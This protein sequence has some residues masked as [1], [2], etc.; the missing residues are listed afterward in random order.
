MNSISGN[1][2]KAI[3]A[4]NDEFESL[5][6]VNLET[7]NYAVFIK[8]KTFGEDINTR[9]LNNGEF[10]F[11]SQLN[12]ENVVYHE[13]R[14]K[15]RNIIT[16]EFI[17]KALSEA[18][19]YDTH[20]RLVVKDRP[21]WVKIRILYKD[22]RKKNIIVGTFN[23]EEEMARRFK[24]EQLRSEL[25]NKM[26]DSDALYIIN[27]AKDTK[28]LVHD[29]YRRG[30]MYHMNECYSESFS[31][32]VYDRVAI[33]DRKMV[34]EMASV[35]YMQDRCRR[36]K[37]YTVEYLDNIAGF[38]RFC[39]MH[40]LML[41]DN[42]ILQSFSLKDKEIVD[43]LLSRKLED[44]FFALYE[45][46]IDTGLLQVIKESNWYRTGGAGTILSY[47]PTMKKFAAEFPMGRTRSFFDRISSIDILKTSLEKD[48]KYTFSFKARTPDGD[49]W[50][51]S[52]GIV[53]F[54]H[55]DGTPSLFAIGFSLIDTLESQSREQQF[56]ISEDMR[57]IVG[58]ANGYH[59]LYYY[60]IDGKIFKIY[61]TDWKR[62]PQAKN[63]VI[64][65]GDPLVMLDKFLQS[66][67][68]FP[69]DKVL[70]KDMSADFIRE[71]LAHRKKW[72]MRFRQNHE[73]KF[74]WVELD[75]IK[76]E[77][78][79]ERANTIAIGFA[80]RDDE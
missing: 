33:Q 44:D 5:Y 53:L 61:S 11:D 40:V 74:K 27:C 35:Q 77:D 68:V 8:G 2:T 18:S 42:E 41:S 10:F 12:I 49:K 60:D 65:N 48:D 80:L 4:L 47:T 73:G 25:I 3:L 37:E 66:D 58:L 20:F 38:N 1:I 75:V 13:D 23:A 29:R 51:S 72:S 14:T 59:S 70:F 43:R 55:K 50:I 79:D 26:T 46:D 17:K 45:I 22:S 36:E 78:I 57:L 54:R 63:F 62:Y 15:V 39:E 56:K 34:I 6:D 31:Q 64:D 71:K 28:K 30:D 32:Y 9:L 24:E 19:H 67:L 16:R 7:G 21:L 76:F 52:T 69:A